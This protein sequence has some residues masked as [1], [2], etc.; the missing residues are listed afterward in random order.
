MG[1]AETHQVLVKNDLRS[2]VILQ[3]DG[4]MRTGR[5][6]VFAALL[7]AE[8]FGFAT[9]P[10][11]AIGLHHDA[12]V[13]PQ[14]LPGGHRDAGP[15]AARQVR[16]HSRSTS[17]RFMFYVAEEA[18]EMMASARLPH[19]AARWSAQVDRS[20][21]KT[22][23]SDHWKAAK[24]D[25]VGRARQ[26][27]SRPGRRSCARRSSRTTASRSAMDNKLIELCAPALERR[28]RSR[29]TS[30]SAT[31]T[32]RWAP[33]SPARSRAATAKTG[34]CRA[35]SSPSFK[36]SAGQSFG[37]FAVDGMEM[38]LEGDAERLR[39][40]GHVGRNPR[41]SGRRRARRFKADE[42]ISMGNTALYG[43][44]S[45][46]AFF[47]GRAGER[48]CVR[49]SGAIAVVEGVGDHGCEYMTGGRV[50]I[51]GMTGRNFAA[52][53]SGGYAYVLDETGDFEKRCNKG[54]VELGSLE[55]G[56]RRGTWRRCAHRARRSAPAAEGDGACSTR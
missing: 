33:C 20:T 43:A 23:P 39:R 16:R 1:L 51:L 41:A 18:R 34:C 4:Q 2:R 38:S 19:A 35:R 46:K 32:A 36:G 49:N 29:S 37:A 55:R 52:G 11:V 26:G 3:A 17:I 12:Q 47:N 15:G 6:V 22:R 8:E 14:H 40:Q 24:L 42:N 53:M 45:G 10:L 25:F 31:S 7:G 44:T 54:M 13:P 5:D 56:R 48:F 28:E 27:R 9:A 50:V 21:V 30:A